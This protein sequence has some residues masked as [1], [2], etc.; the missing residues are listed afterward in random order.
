ML[1]PFLSRLPQETNFE[2]LWNEQLSE[3]YTHAPKA[4]FSPVPNDALAASDSR[5]LDEGH[6][7]FLV[8][9][10][11]QVNRDLVFP[12]RALY[13]VGLHLLVADSNRHP[14]NPTL[15]LEAACE[16]RISAM[17]AA[18]N[19]TSS[20][21][22]VLLNC[23]PSPSEWKLSLEWR[24][25]EFAQC[26]TY[27]LH[28]LNRHAIAL[29]L[30]RI[31]TPTADFLAFCEAALVLE[32]FG[33]FQKEI[34]NSGISKEHLGYVVCD[35]FPSLKSRRVELLTRKSRLTWRP[36]GPDEKSVVP[37]ESIG[38]SGFV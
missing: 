29:F 18:L 10:L 32:E 36:E 26:L 12:T 9:R 2:R 16:F 22:L 4:S 20:D 7:S 24:A 38:L 1:R 5:Y 35:I 23:L 13:H 15:A 30:E 11:N 34:A 33:L 25:I 19:C 8:A 21:L 14:K 17:E 3:Q 37:E 28:S 31:Q 27:D 6:D